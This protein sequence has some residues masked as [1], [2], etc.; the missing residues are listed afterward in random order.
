MPEYLY[1]NPDT[2][3]ITTFESDTYPY[4]YRI[5]HIRAIVNQWQ[6]NDESTEI[7]EFAK[8]H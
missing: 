1:E 6:V 8:Q 7:D 5:E 3:E 4:P 2:G